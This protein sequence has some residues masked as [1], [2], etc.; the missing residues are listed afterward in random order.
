MGQAALEAL[1]LEVGQRYL[2]YGMDYFD[3][4]WFLRTLISETQLNFQQPFDLNKV[5]DYQPNL[6]DGEMGSV[7]YY[8]D[9]N[10]NMIQEI[11]NWNYY[12]NTIGALDRERTYYKAFD[13]DNIRYANS[14]RLTVYDPSALPWTYP[15][16]R[17]PY[18]SVSYSERSY[19][20]CR[21]ASEFLGTGFHVVSVEDYIEDYAVPTYVRLDGTVEEFLASEDG[22]LWQQVIEDMEINNHSFPVLA[23]EKIGYQPDFARQMVRIVEG[24]DFTESEL[25]NGEKVCV[26]SQ[27]IAVESGLEVG[28]TISI[29]T[30]PTDYNL[31]PYKEKKTIFYSPPAYPSAAFYSRA[32]GF[33]GEMEV[34]TIVGLYRHQSNWYGSSSY[35]FTPNTVFIPKASTAGTMELDTDGIYKSYILENGKIEEFLKIV[36]DS[37]YHGLFSCY[38]QG[39][40]RM[41]SG[42][43][44]Y[45]EVSI[46]ALYVGFVAYCVILLLFM[47]L[48][49]IHQREILSAMRS[50]GAD[51]QMRISHVIVSSIGLLIP[52]SF[53]G[54]ISSYLLWEHVTT[55]LTKSVETSV[56]LT[57]ST[58]VLILIAVLQ[59][60]AALLAVFITA[61][62]MTRETGG[63]K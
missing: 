18:Y 4:D 49:P 37:G 22:I 53:L 43:D 42:L 44:A 16:D 12:E 39:Y 57:A 1:D 8:P 51:R 14:C 19:H 62:T 23:V 3:Q 21:D 20:T 36:D 52:G 45:A 63:K 25:I 2:I 13:A 35:G 15:T 48:F 7:S 54:L 17:F 46:R 56:S 50:L 6:S 26:I 47:L 41:K 61:L 10:G 58:T 40:T 55:I 32:M 30:Y 60:F 9:E 38:D 27:T 5:Y 59:L 28:D 11:T 29:Q 24:R 33:D 31:Y 34:Y